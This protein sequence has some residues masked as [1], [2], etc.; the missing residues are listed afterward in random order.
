M[1]TRFRIA[2]PFAAVLLLLAA[3]DSPTDLKLVAVPDVTLEAVGDSKQLE[4]TVRGT[5]QLPIWESLHP[6]IAT[7]TRAGMVTAVAPGAATVRARLGSETR[8]GTVTVLPPVSVEI[9][10]ASKQPADDGVEQITLRMRNTGGRGYYRT[11]FYRA[12][13]TPGGE[14]QIISQDFNDHDISALQPEMTWGTQVAAPAHWVVVYSREPQSLG[15]R[16][17]ACV[18][19]DGGAGC[20]AP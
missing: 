19:L 1:N 11:R 6:D 4:A 13:A 7:V 17:T 16:T 2:S 18:R 3:C 5:E 9:T 12:S 8:E 15:Y 14:P 10:S 20:P